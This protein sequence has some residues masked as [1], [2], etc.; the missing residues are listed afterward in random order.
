MQSA[1][2]EV[3]VGGGVLDAAPRI[4]RGAAADT[5]GAGEVFVEDRGVVVRSLLQLKERQRGECQG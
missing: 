3:G 1:L 2:G 5:V 4:G